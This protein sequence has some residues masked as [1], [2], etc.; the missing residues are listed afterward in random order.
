[1]ATVPDELVDVDFTDADEP[2]VV[3]PVPVQPP[4]PLSVRPPIAT[5]A[6]FSVADVELMITAG[7]FADGRRCELI[8]GLIV[9]TMPRGLTHIG[10]VNRL[11]DALNRWQLLDEMS[12]SGPARF[13]VSKEDPLS[14]PAQ[15]SLPEP[16]IM[17][18]VGDRSRYADRRPEAAD[19][20]LVVEVADTS[21]AKDK[22]LAAIYA[23]AGVP[24]YLLVDVNDR[25]MTL[26]EQ[27]AAEGYAEVRDVDVVP[28]AVDG[29][30]LGQI[31]RDAVFGG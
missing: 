5:L 2:A 31:D 24:R 29:E 18:L 28:V 17:L 11:V 10:C 15:A 19:T 20:L 4:L 13:C 6:R 16:D 26:H 7:V 9:E 30:E 14:L 25:T 1:M 23:A 8:E 12:R 27:P 22:R 3:D 21:L